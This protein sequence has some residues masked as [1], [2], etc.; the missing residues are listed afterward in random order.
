M[1]YQKLV[2]KLTQEKVKNKYSPENLGKIRHNLVLI[3]ALFETT[4]WTRK[5]NKSLF[6][7]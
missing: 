5:E 2:K 7:I 6:N 3:S 1:T 4:I